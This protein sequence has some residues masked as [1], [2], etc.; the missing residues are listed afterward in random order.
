MPRSTRAVFLRVVF[1]LH[2]AMVATAPLA[3]QVRLGPEAVGGNYTVNVMSWWDIP[4]RSIVRQRYDFS[5]GSAAVATLLTHQYGIQTAEAEPFKAMWN[6]GDRAKIKQVGF[7]MLDMKTYLRARGFNAE[8]FRLPIDELRKVSQ[9]A[10]A[11]IDLDGYKHFVVVKGFVGNTVLVGDPVRG[12]TKYDKGQFAKMWNG[13]VLMITKV[14]MGVT[15]RYNLAQDWNPWS[16]A[17]IGANAQV[18]SVG[19][20]TTFLPPNIR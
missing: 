7:S 16:T 8:G 9:P 1:A 4:F 15:P 10:I 13:I 11:L 3:A 17:P 5:C 6:A 2:T 12:L 18:A 20:L 19:D 14:P